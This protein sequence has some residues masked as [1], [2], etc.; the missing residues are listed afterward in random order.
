VTSKRKILMVSPVVPYP[1]RENG[2]ALR[3][4]PVIDSLHSQYQLDIVIIDD[5]DADKINGLAQ[6][7]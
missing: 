2:T 6:H 3:Y 4:L 5:A 1:L 7:C